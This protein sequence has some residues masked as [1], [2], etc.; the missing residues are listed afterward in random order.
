[1]VCDWS[2]QK[3]ETLAEK[4]KI[5]KACGVA[6]V[7]EHLLSKHKALSLIPSTAKKNDFRFFKCISNALYKY[8]SCEPTEP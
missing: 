8:C 4:I 7:V 5:R 3:S 6:Q 2:G 1:M